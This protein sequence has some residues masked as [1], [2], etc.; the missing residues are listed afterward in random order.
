MAV[1]RL[2]LGDA[3]IL[4]PLYNGLVADVPFCWPVSAEEFAAGAAR[5]SA[6]DRLSD[7]L[8]AQRLLVSR[9]GDDIL[10]F[11]HTALETQDGETRGIIRFIGYAPGERAAG[12]ELLRTAERRLRDVGAREALAFAHD[13]SYPFYHLAFGYL[14][15]RLGHVLGLLGINGYK[16]APEGSYSRREE[17]FFDWPDYDV[18]R[19]ESPDPMLTVDV[20]PQEGAGRLPNVRFHMRRDGDHVG[21]CDTNCVGDWSRAEEAQDA[22]FVTWLGIDD[23]WQGN[24]WGRFLLL[25]AL[26]ELKR[27]G[28]RRSTISTNLTN[29]RAMTF[30]ANLGY[31]VVGNGYE[32]TKSLV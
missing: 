17:V 4:A 14:S 16:V 31:E 12:Q 32:F 28:Y 13:Y 21:V 22:F 6:Y 18:A 20:Q 19:P 30:Y 2:E 11:A 5:Q 1:T 29:Y 3:G 9:R 15:D 7:R 25:S 8:D 23:E 10:G 26:Y 24:G 27:L